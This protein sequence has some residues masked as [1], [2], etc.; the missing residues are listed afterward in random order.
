MAG[1]RTW[2]AALAAAMALGMVGP[3]VA[4]ETDDAIEVDGGS[5]RSE[6]LYE[7]LVAERR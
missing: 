1:K 7:F 6:A 3:S 4:D 2:W 5:A